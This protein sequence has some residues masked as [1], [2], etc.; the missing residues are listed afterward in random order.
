MSSLQRA[1]VDHVPQHNRAPFLRPQVDLHVDEE[2]EDEYE[3]ED[4]GDAGV[5]FGGGGDA[6]V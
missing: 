5:Y 1:L 3:D 2:D 6:C 4:E